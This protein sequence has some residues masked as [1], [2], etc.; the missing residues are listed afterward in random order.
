MGVN[1][2]GGGENHDHPMRVVKR[3]DEMSSCGAVVFT[4][5]LII[6]KIIFIMINKVVYKC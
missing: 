2:A 4:Y 1:M 5:I 6:N 3:K